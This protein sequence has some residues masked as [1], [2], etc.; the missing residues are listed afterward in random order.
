MTYEDMIDKGYLTAEKND[1]YKATTY[2]GSLGADN[3][4]SLKVPAHA[5]AGYIT[6]HVL[7]IKRSRVFSSW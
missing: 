3:M 2:R 1:N 6:P 4:Y 7:N 5:R